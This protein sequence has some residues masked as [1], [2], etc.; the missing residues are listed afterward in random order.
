MGI[1]YDART[2]RP[3]IK[4]HRATDEFQNESVRNETNPVDSLESAAQRSR[5]NLILDSSD[6]E[7]AMDAPSST[8]AVDLRNELDC[9]VRSNDRVRYSVSVGRICSLRV[10]G[11]HN[12]YHYIF[13]TYRRVCMHLGDLLLMHSEKLL[14]KVDL[15]NMFIQD[16]DGWIDEELNRYDLMLED[17]DDVLSNQVNALERTRAPRKFALSS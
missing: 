7:D 6:D 10:L 9:Q 4:D 1:P 11:Y 15:L 3:F 13:R 5:P 14:S 2:Y 12:V 8:W 16:D 17:T